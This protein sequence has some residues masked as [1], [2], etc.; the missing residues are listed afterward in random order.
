MEQTGMGTPGRNPR[1]GGPSTDDAGAAGHVD[2]IERA[3]REITENT[4]FS[5][6]FGGLISGRDLFVT[7]FSGTRTLSLRGLRVRQ[8]LGLGGLAMAEQRPR[9]TLDYATSPLITHDYDGPVL[10]EGVISLMAIP[11]V[12]DG[13]VRGIVYGGSHS[14]RAPDSITAQPAIMAAQR[15]SAEIAIREEV[16]RRFAR[17]AAQQ[18]AAS[19][20]RLAPRVREG[21]REQHAELRSLI[22]E[23]AEAA[24]RARLERVSSELAA[25]ISPAPPEPP[26]VR[27]SPREIDVLAGAGLGRSN[28]EIGGALGLTEGTVKSYLSTAMT[29]LDARSR[30]AAVSEARKQ[31][32]LP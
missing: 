32:L 11:I 23:T 30:H 24:T 14:L 9:L 18:L 13:L 26:A 1:F 15:V 27:L 4:G 6:S 28:A 8:S 17:L 10:A 25:L 29:K 12:V 20:T 5:L 19:H 21:L 16:D 7:A 22:A 3:T 2:L 31:G